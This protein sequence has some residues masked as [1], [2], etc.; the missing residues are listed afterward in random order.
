MHQQSLPT[1]AHFVCK[2]HYAYCIFYSRC[3]LTTR[4]SLQIRI[5]DA[6]LPRKIR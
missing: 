3:T 5:R 2:M 4:R 1:S 6:A